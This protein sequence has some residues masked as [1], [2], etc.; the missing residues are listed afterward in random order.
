MIKN[1]IVANR[2]G[3]IGINCFGF[4]PVSLGHNIFGDSTCGQNVSGGAGGGSTKGA[5]CD[6]GSFEFNSTPPTISATLTGTLGTNGLY[7][8]D[9]EVTWFINDAESNVSSSTV[10]DTAV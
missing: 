4:T 3:G 8:G 1:S 6:I 5:A 7:T 10:C 2:T 9:A